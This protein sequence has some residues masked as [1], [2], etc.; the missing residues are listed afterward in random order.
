MLQSSTKFK[1]K[2][3]LN[4]A[5]IFYHVDIP[6]QVCLEWDDVAG[7]SKQIYGLSSGVT[8]SGL[9]GPIYPTKFV[10]NGMMLQV[11]PKKF[12][13]LHNFLE[14]SC[15][16]SLNLEIDRVVMRL[17]KTVSKYRKNG[18][19]SQGQSENC[20]TQEQSKSK[21]YLR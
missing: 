16:L 18:P 14:K 15:K 6:N 9:A 5:D 17:K 4:G 20:F 19:C 3:N 12:T 21:H 2:P 1:N 11:I 8:V 10:W 7:Y 13:L